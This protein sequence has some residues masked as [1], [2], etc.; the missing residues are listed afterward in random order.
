MSFNAIFRFHSFKLL[1]AIVFFDCFSDFF[2]NYF[3][4][5]SDFFQSLTFINLNSMKLAERIFAEEGLVLQA[6]CRTFYDHRE[7]VRHMYNT[8]VVIGFAAGGALVNMLYL[9][10]SALVVELPAPDEEVAAAF[11]TNTLPNMANDLAL[12]YTRFTQTPRASRSGLTFAEG[13]LRKMRTQILSHLTHF[14]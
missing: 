2:S 13:A 10:E 7:L 3:F 12:R 1:L 11:D 9:K 4:Q 5:F 14:R 8:D 6:C